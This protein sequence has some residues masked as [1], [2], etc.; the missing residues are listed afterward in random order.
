METYKSGTVV[1]PGTF[2]CITNAHLRLMEMGGRVF[3]GDFYVLVATK[4]GKNPW[5]S[6]EERV[7][8]IKDSLDAAYVGLDG[9]GTNYI[10]PI[11][12]DQRIKVIPVT[13]SK[14]V[15]DVMKELN[16]KYVLRGLR[17]ANDFGYEQRLMRFY[18]IVNPEIV[19]IY[20][21]SFPEHHDDLTSSS[22]VKELV[23]P[24]GWKKMVNLFLPPP[25]RNQFITRAYE[26]VP[27]A[28]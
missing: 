13:N 1:Y 9:N 11:P 26:K 10:I 7:Q 24:Y 19:P 3:S 22:A 12:E 18:R 14:Y 17:D 8:M 6:L 4:A 27:D 20:I 25:I 16:A 15:P 28:Q 23:G 5:F 21:P 2:D